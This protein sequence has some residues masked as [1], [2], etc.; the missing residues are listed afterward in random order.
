VKLDELAT[1]AW[2]FIPDHGIINAA[3]W[4]P[5]G[6]FLVLSCFPDYLVILDGETGEVVQR[7]TGL[8][9]SHFRSFWSSDGSHLFSYVHDEIRVWDVE[10]WNVVRR[11]TMPTEGSFDVDPHGTVV[12]I[13]YHYNRG[14]IGWGRVDLWR[15]ADGAK[16][17]TIE[18]K[19]DV[20]GVA[21]SASGQ[22][23]TWSN[24]RSVRVWDVDQASVVQ[25]LEI[26]S[27]T[28][29]R[30]I[31]SPSGSSIVVASNTAEICVFDAASAEL[32]FRLDA[33]CDPHFSVFGV[34]AIALATDGSWLASKSGDGKV[35]LWNTTDWSP[36]AVFQPRSMDWRMK[37]VP[38]L[39]IKPNERTI[40]TQNDDCTGLTVWQLSERA[41]RPVT[42]PSRTERARGDAK[43]D[44]S[45]EEE[46]YRPIV[47]S[48]SE[49]QRLGSFTR[50][51]DIPG[52][53]RDLERDHGPLRNYPLFH[54]WSQPDS[55]IDILDGSTWKRSVFK[56]WDGKR[57]TCEHDGKLKQ[58]EFHQSTVAPAGHF[59]DFH[60]DEYSIASAE[61]ATG[62]TLPGDGWIV[63]SS[64]LVEIEWPYVT[65]RV[66]RIPP[67]A[68]VASTFSEDKLTFHV[69]DPRLTINGVTR[70]PAR[71]NSPV[72]VSHRWLAPDHPDADGAQY[73]ELLERALAMKFHPMQPFLIDYCALPQKPWTLAEEETFARHIKPFH[74]AFTASSII[75]ERGAED[76]GTRAWCMLELMLIA[77]EGWSADG[78]DKLRGAPE[79]PFGLGP[80]WEEAT[81][82]LQ[83]SNENVRNLG[84]ALADSP[85]DP[86]QAYFS[87]NRNFAFR[88]AMKK[89]QNRLLALFDKELNVTDPS[90]R[91]TIRKI[92]RELVFERQF[93]A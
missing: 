73:R 26:R 33:H 60:D 44:A 78:P 83:L 34:Y 80:A 27:G 14:L 92:L 37:Q 23:A 18:T 4:S 93:R 54:G 8:Q 25:T 56:A 59:T 67:N 79:L 30:T 72:A 50:W 49:L 75:I 3:S 15:T 17:A 29:K 9:Y 85:T 6:R 82:Y 68:V 43:S 81:N 90:D 48:L 55:D 51:Q 36:F 47:I 39:A 70:P 21:L 91:P 13:G 58:L 32:R 66:K 69:A 22:L 76:Y 64:E 28:P 5:D 10:S 24:S 11:F 87:D 63:I 57:I 16:A 7:L 20:S 2:S 84:R 71:F 35:L 77:I 74:T 31:W 41:G 38:L 40:L 42:T 89:Q 52:R 61:L 65:L 19:A 88:Q 62:T 46:H 1:E 12:A 86:F 45:S 53:L